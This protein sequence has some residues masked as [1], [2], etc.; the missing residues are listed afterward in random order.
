MKL[1]RLRVDGFGLLRGE[2]TFDPSRVTVVVDDNERGKTS[3][4]HAIAAALYGL[5][6]DGRRHRG[7]LTPLE[8]WRPWDG[9]EY[10]VEL[11]LERDGQPYDIVRD[12]GRGTVSVRGSRGEELAP[13]FRDGKDEFN[14]GRKLLGLD[15]DEFVKCAFWRQGELDDV[16]PDQERER[17]VSTLHARLEEAV[18]SREGKGTAVNALQ[19]LDRA[20][21]KLSLIHI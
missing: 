16:V 12:F 6:G 11:A 5:E 3:M 2:W 17:R 1:L 7:L 10:R 14:V 9:G 18:D 21:Q 4:L 20:M 15:F 19:V 8:R 13:E